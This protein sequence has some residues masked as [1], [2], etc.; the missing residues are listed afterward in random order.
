[1]NTPMSM[2]SP[3]PMAPPIQ[4]PVPR[5]SVAAPIAAPMPEPRTARAGI[6]CAEL[7]LYPPLSAIGRPY[8]SQPRRSITL[9]SGSTTNSRSPAGGI[10]V[11]AEHPPVDRSADAGTVS[12]SWRWV[13]PDRS[14][15]VQSSRTDSM[16]R[17]SG[18]GAFARRTGRRASGPLRVG[19]V[20]EVG[21]RRY[22]LHGEQ[23]A[24][25]ITSPPIGGT[26][27][28]APPATCWSFRAGSAAVFA[29]L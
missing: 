17:T 16:A 9:A 26:G 13:E 11:P 12:G 19:P 22:D 18:R 2:A 4:M 8:F 5:L 28:S 23:E 10:Q 20:R 25:A 6:S 14:T 27:S 15:I 24:R 7:R 1:M 29:T 21:V 3:T